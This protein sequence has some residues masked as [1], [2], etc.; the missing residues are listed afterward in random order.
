MTAPETEIGGILRPQSWRLALPEGLKLLNENQTRRMHWHAKSDIAAAIR[1][2]ATYA[3]RQALRDGMPPMQRAHIFYVIHP[4]PRVT[5]RDPANWA[6]SAKAAIDGLVDAGVLPDDDST[7]CLG[8][9]PRI[10]TPIKGSQLVLWITDLDQ[11]HPHHLALL[12][13]PHTLPGDPR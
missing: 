2:A 8:G 9:D 12:N 10:G 6:Q 3:A 11:I 1:A 7:R 4:G 13:P 5:R